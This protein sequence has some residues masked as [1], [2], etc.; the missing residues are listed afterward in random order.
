MNCCLAVAAAGLTYHYRPAVVARITQRKRGA[1]RARRSYELRHGHG[2][3]FLARAGA[4]RQLIMQSMGHRTLSASGA[5]Y[6][7]HASIADKQA[8]IAK[9]FG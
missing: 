5:R 9:V 7:A 3:Q 2:Y 4:S 1:G 6:A 8:V